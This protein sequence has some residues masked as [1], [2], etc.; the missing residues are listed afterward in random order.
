M[1]AR[2]FAASAPIAKVV[3]SQ[4]KTLG[5]SAIS[6]ESQL[7]NPFQGLRVTPSSYWMDAVRE[8]RAGRKRSRKGKHGQG[9]GFP[10]VSI[11]V[12]ALAL[13]LDSQV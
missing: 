7:A 5:I 1:N 6:I 13:D 3:W 11:S 9:V 2:S 12:R 4:G 10:P 8:R